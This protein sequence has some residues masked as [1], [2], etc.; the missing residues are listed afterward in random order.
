MTKKRSKLFAL[1]LT[2]MLIMSSVVSMP[3]VAFAAEN[4]AV[5]PRVLFVNPVS[6]SCNGFFTGIQSNNNA[7]YGNIPAGTYYFSYSY[8][9]ENIV[10]TI[11]IESSSERITRN[12]IGDGG[13]HDT[14]EFHLSG[15]T[16]TVTI[17]AAPQAYQM[18]KYY[19]YDLIL[20]R[21]GW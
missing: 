14:S 7:R 20:D 12:L 6:G 2:L 15:G 8:A 10:G 21:Y 17:I 13:G 18:E 19:S 5:Q 11:V 1:M 9:S 16:Y 3:T 4:E